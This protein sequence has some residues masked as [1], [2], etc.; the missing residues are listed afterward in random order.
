MAIE[1]NSG[2]ARLAP[3][4]LSWSRDAFSLKIVHRSD[5]RFWLRV[6]LAPDPAIVVSDLT[7]SEQ[8]P[9]CAAIALGFAVESLG[10]R[11][12]RPL[13]FVFRDISPGR[14][15]AEDARAAEIRSVLNAFAADTARF[16]KSVELVRSD[17]KT[18]L[19]AELD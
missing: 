12:R 17:A 1:F 15:A 2:E 7:L 18:A 4:G 6:E 14:P 5:P 8:P 3:E 19:R 16:V 13:T 10:A 9:G 11:A